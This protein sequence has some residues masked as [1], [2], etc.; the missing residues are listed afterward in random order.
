MYN[1]DLINAARN[2]NETRVRFL[3]ENEAD[4][5][6][7]ET[8]GMTALMWS[9]YNGYSGIVRILLDFG[10]DVDIQN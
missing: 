1:M 3:L 6:I 9:S 10:A 2:G 8:D 5:D 4:V 7:R